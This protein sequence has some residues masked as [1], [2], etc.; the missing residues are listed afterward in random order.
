MFTF[1]LFSPTNHVD[2]VDFDD[3]ISHVSHAFLPHPNCSTHQGSMCGVRPPSIHFFCA[4]FWIL[5]L[6][7]NLASSTL[8]PI[9]TDMS[10]CCVQLI[11]L[12]DVSGWYYAYCTIYALLITLRSTLCTLH[13]AYCTMHIAPCMLHQAHCTKHAA[14]G[15]YCILRLVI[16]LTLF[17]IGFSVYRPFVCS[18]E[19]QS[20]HA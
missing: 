1:W 7:E 12:P 17:I 2:N 5:R 9:H 10:S 16:C 19:R 3:R 11:C 15:W 20:L 4:V 18:N 8:Q 13:Y 14:S 6:V